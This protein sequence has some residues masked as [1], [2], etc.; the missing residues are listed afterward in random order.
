[1]NYYLGIYAL[2]T[3]AVVIVDTL[4]WMVLYTGGIR[5]ST[6]MYKAILRNTLRAP[7]RFFDTMALGRLLNRFGK[8]FEQIDAALPDHLGKTIV[9][10]DRSEGIDNTDT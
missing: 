7:L 6:V 1:M 10:Q 4:Q 3:V 5:A 2:I 9:S 8:D